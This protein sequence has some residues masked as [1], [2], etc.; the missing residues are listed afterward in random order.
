LPAGD[1][2]KLAEIIAAAAAINK[3]VRFWA[4]PDTP[5]AWAT[6]LRLKAGYLNTDHIEAL[7]RFFENH[8]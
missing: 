2:S 6:L 8:R 3:P 4:A 5:Q 1:S 7:S